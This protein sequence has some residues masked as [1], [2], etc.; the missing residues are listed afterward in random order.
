MKAIEINNYGSTE[1][2]QY[3][4]NVAIPGFGS[5]DILVHNKVTSVNPVDIAKCEGYGKPIFEKK[6]QVKFPWIM[7]NDVAGIVSKVGTKV[8]KFKVGDEIFSAPSV[9]RQGTG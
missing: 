8:T 4:E 5:N 1:V 3:K 6:R 7:G 2:L 9:H